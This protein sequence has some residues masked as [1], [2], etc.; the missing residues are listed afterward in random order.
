MPGGGIAAVTGRLSVVGLGMLIFVPLTGTWGRIPARSAAAFPGDG[1][2]PGRPG[3][4]PLFWPAIP[5]RNLLFL[6]IALAHGFRRLLPPYG[7]ERQVA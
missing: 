5:P 2:P 6:A 7:T 1:T 4:Q 3:L